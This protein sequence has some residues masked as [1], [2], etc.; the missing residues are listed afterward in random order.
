[1]RFYIFLM[2]MATTRIAIILRPIS[3]WLAIRK[4]PPILPLYPAIGEIHEHWPEILYMFP[5][6][7]I[8]RTP[9]IEG[10]S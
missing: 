1:M 8:F 4:I 6:F 9:V 2:E 5:I 10:Y 3:E 7:F